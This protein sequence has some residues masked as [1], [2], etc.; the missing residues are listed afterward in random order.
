M[1]VTEYKEFPTLIV[2]STLT[3]IGLT[4]MTFSDV[5]EVIE[6]LF[7]GPVWTHEFVHAPTNDIYISRGYEQFPNMPTQFDAEKDWKGAAE[8]AVAA[9]GETVIVAKGENGRQA[10]PLQTIRDIKPD[11]KIIPV[12]VP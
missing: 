7:G 1:P 2:A 4:N 11:V 12:I 3:G 5:H 9:Y 6:W 10:S 8:K